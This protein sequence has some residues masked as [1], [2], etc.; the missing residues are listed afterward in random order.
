VSQPINSPDELQRAVEE[1]NRLSTAADGS[2][3]AKRRSEL[4]GQIKAYYAQ[5]KE[6]LATGRP[7]SN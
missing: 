2:P 5:G 4:E 1:F 3:E 7:R 6:D